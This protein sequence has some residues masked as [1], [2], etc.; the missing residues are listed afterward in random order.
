MPLFLLVCF[1]EIRT[2]YLALELAYVDRL[3]L[4][5]R[6]PPEAASQCWG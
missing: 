1:N 3:V 5:S 2:H 4:N 6:D